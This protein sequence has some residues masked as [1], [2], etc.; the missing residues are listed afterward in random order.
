MIV[1]SFL[2]S[3]AMGMH[4]ERL[5]SAAAGRQKGSRQ[6]AGTSR[7]GNNDVN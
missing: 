6:L 3:S 5:A 2:P 7:K 1:H 4:G